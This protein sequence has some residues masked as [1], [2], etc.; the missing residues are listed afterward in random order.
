[1]I[2][3]LYE[4]VGDTEGREVVGERLGPELGRDVVGLAEGL[5][6]VGEVVGEIDG[7]EVV[8]DEEG[9]K[10]GLNV[11]TGDWVGVLLGASVGASHASHEHIMACG[12]EQAAVTFPG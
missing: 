7:L 11:G 4:V 2:I 12:V 3:P 1:V 8:G 10:D 6:V 9:T 5:E